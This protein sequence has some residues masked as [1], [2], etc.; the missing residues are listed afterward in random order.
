MYVISELAETT[1]AAEVNGLSGTQQ[2]H[3]IGEQ[4]ADCMIVL[5]DIAG[6]CLID[7]EDEVSK[8]LSKSIE[9]LTFKKRGMVLKKLKN[10][11]KDGYEG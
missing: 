6:G 3:L 8:K 4:L 11:L 2:A 9:I 10:S 1:K 7:L 5:A